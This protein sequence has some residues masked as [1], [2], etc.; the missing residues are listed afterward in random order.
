M[1]QNDDAE[2]KSTLRIILWVYLV[3]I[4][5]LLVTLKYFNVGGT[6]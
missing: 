4:S 2:Y 6:P 3:F 1:T 5:I